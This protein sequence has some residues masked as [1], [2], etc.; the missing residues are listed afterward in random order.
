MS[1]AARDRVIERPLGTLTETLQSKLANPEHGS[2]F[3]LHSTVNDVVK[4]V[5]LS[6]ADSGGKLSF[7]G[8]NPILP[9]PHRLGT[10]ASVGLAAKAIAVAALWRSRTGDSMSV[11]PTPRSIA[12]AVPTGLLR[13]CLTG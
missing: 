1:S 13:D 6:T 8:Q 7:Y 3:D 2:N 11:Y 9:S 4:D 10:M 5:G 12:G